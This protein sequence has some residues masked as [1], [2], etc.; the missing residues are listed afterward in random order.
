[1]KRLILVIVAILIITGI[2]IVVMGRNYYGLASEL[3]C[4]RELVCERETPQCH[5]ELGDTLR[6][7]VIGDSW[8]FRHQ[9]YN[10]SLAE[11]LSKQTH[12][13]V[14][15]S[16]YGLSGKTSKEF[17]LCLFEDESISRV[18][19][20]TSFCF[21]SVGINDTYRKI[22]LTYYIHHTILIL[23]YLLKKNITPI[24]LE[25]PDY[26]IYYAYNHQTYDRKLLRRISML[27]THSPLD[28]RR[29]Y[30]EAMRQ[31]LADE[32]LTD[33]VLVV[34]N[35]QWDMTHYVADRMHLNSQG[36][37]ALDSCIVSCILQSGH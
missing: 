13:P 28:C 19:D 16:S 36:Y 27:I 17:Y 30:R 21:V 10:A 12:R 23:R 24:L 25:I 35:Q 26:D 6:L 5:K 8:A 33:K 29:E 14:K 32:H 22:G 7:S 4:C 9:D 20:G 18:V 15:V 31:V 3:C 11:E 1:M 37:K 34:S 2:A